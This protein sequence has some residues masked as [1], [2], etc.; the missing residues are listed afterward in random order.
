MRTPPGTP[1]EAHSGG[2]ASDGRARAAEP[3]VAGA[4]RSRGR[5][6][7]LRLALCLGSLAGT[8]VLLE[9]VLRTAYALGIMTP[10]DT[11]SG[12]DETAAYERNELGIRE[13]WD[14]VPGGEDAIRIA[15]LGDSFT[16]GYGVE[17]EQTFVHLLEKAL[18]RGDRKRY[19]TIN[20]GQPGTDAAAHARRYRRLKDTLRPDVVVHVLYCND[21]GHDLQEE[22]KAIHA[23][24]RERS[25]MAQRSC[26][27]QFVEGHLRA[28]RVRRRTI[29]FYR[30]G[31]SPLKREHGWR[32]L[33][34]GVEK[35]LAMAREDGTPYLLVLFP[36]LYSL[37]DYP[38]E[39]VHERLGGLSAELGVPFLDLLDTFR[40]RDARDVRVSATDEHP[41]PEGHR[42]AAEALARFLRVEG[43]LD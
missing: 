25:P 12:E 10:D 31:D 4:R 23:L 15:F 36:W 24:L 13:P 29:A 5:L 20:I 30:G 21:L 26:L 3:T 33:R 18:N 27:W 17:A 35:V 41:N 9:G 2:R 8:V 28:P 7:L 34:A 19:V 6:W 11:E 43:Y 16:F 22:L 40:G 42:L 38:L 37:D 39:D 14:R 1:P 32:H